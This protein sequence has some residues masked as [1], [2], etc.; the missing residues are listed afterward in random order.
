MEFAPGGIKLQYPGC[1][2]FQLHVI[3]YENIISRETAC[4]PQ[5]NGITFNYRKF[6]QIPF[7]EKQVRLKF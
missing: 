4:T 6:L 3:T 1:I 2:F 7:G 5:E